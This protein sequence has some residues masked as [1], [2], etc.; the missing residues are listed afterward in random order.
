MNIAYKINGAFFLLLIFIC[1]KFL[2][3]YDN[4]NASVI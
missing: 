3:E 1:V 4:F 2:Y